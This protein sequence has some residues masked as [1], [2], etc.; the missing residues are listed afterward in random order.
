[1]NAAIRRLS[2]VAFVLLMALMIAVTHI[3]VVQAPT[4][5]AD[6]R[7]IRTTYREFGLSRGPII[8]DGKSVASSK[9]SDD[10]FGYQRSYSD[11]PLYA[12]M[13]GYFSILVG[14][15]GIERT[16]NELLNGTADSLA[17]RRLQDLVTGRQPKGSSVE[18][19][20]Q[21]AAQQAAWD[22][23]GDQK[24]AAVA[25]DPRTGAILAMVSKPSYDPNDLAVH[26][27]SKVDKS[28]QA[29]LAG[30]GNPLL[31][32]TT[33]ATY[34]PGSTFKLL[35]SAAAIESGALTPDSQVPAPTQ[36]QLPQ[37]SATLGNFGGSACSPTGTMTLADALRISCNTA[38]A[39]IGMDLGQDVLR[40]TTEAFGFNDS[41]EVPLAVAPSVFPT[42]IDAPG[43]ALSSI[44][45]K[46]VRATPLQ[47]ALVAATIAND[48]VQ[49]SPYSV[50]TVRDADLAV[51]SE[52]E[53]SER[54]TA[55]SPATAQALT[56]MMVGVVDS[57]SGRAAQINGVKVAGKT[58][59]AQT[60]A[61]AA[62]HAWFVGFAPADDPQ[63]AVAVIVENGGSLGSEGTGG[64]VAAPVARSIMRAVMDR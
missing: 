30:T 59:T 4:L 60:T 19:T 44:G 31:N 3:Q 2:V 16:E 37:S 40:E 1:M 11:G 46:D 17:I 47:M 27:T 20:L 13:T 43:V 57:G 61:D 36:L 21:A 64:A 25:I 32:R 34:P 12:P 54:T 56:D 7:N 10:A 39:Q 52:A 33:Q 48:G 24:G 6:S 5:N 41:L 22:A 35:V 9:A 51:I 62:P 28:Y 45:Q 42:D 29:L 26:S 38:F 50:Q 15:S 18:L 58:G 49:M 55:I 8:V 53:P 23:L 63:V 14:R